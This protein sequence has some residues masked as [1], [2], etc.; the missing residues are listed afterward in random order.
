MKIYLD[1]CC[2]SRPFNDQ[3]QIRIQ[4]ETQAIQIILESF[5]TGEWQWIIS[6]VLV[7]EVNK[8]KD[9][10]QR[11]RIKLLMDR[12][13]QNIL[14]SI[15]KMTDNEIYRLGIEVL[16]SKLGTEGVHRFL[17]LCG[18]CKGD[19]TVERHEWLDDFPDINTIIE[20]GQQAREAE[21][22]TQI[23]TTIQTD[24]SRNKNPS[25][26]HIP[27]MTGMELHEAGLRILVEKL[28][29][30]GM[31]RFIQLCS[32]ET[33]IYAIEPNK[34]SELDIEGIIHE[35]TGKEYQRKYS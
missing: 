28:T 23:T 35:A 8:N 30:A 14:M 31:P 12:A 3:T 7:T 22:S 18:P 26:L 9:W 11:D 2:L 1:T 25:A 34:L 13:N 6:E 17:N 33:G 27:K 24:S 19:Y 4:R 5:V 32:Q 21:Q 20:E 15:R 29:I 16:A 10:I